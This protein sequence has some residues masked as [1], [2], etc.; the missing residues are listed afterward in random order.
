MRLVYVLPPLDPAMAPAAVVVIGGGVAYFWLGAVLDE[1]V[2][3]PL[4]PVIYVVT[5]LFASSD[6]T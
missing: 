6:R 1:G 4:N 3:L 2:L 5:F